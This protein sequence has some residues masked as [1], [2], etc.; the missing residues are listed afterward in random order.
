LKTHA[1]VEQIKHHAY[2]C[3]MKFCRKNK[4]DPYAEMMIGTSKL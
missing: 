1:F 3:C 2:Y 4:T